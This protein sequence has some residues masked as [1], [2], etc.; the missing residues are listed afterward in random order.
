MLA[1]EQEPAL[2]ATWDQ[3]LAGVFAR[4]CS[5]C[6]LPDGVSGTDL[7]TPEGWQSER[8]V[9]RDRVLVGRTMPPEGHALSDADRASIAAWATGGR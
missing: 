7:S 8:A 6:H 4:A 5:A 1:P 9:I 3:T 2:G